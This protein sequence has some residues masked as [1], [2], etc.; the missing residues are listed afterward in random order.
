[1]LDTNTRF[2]VRSP[3]GRA[4]DPMINLQ[5]GQVLPSAPCRIAPRPL[6]VA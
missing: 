4:A 1:M 5:P 2:K 3:S 6:R